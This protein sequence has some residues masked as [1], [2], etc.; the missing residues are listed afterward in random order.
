MGK[1]GTCQKAW[2]RLNCVPKKQYV[3]VLSPSISECDLVRKWGPC[4]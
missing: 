3:E 1:G 4:R 2:Y